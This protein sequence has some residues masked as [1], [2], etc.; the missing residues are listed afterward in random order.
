MTLELVTKSFDVTPVTAGGQ[1]FERLRVPA[2][3]HGF[4]LEP[5]LPQ[6]PLKGILMEIPA[7]QTGAGRGAGCHEPGA[8][9]L[10]GLPGAVAPGG[11]EQP[12][13]GGLQLGRGRLPRERLLPGGCGGAF[14]RV[15]VPG[16]GAAAADLLPPAVQPG[17]RGAAAL[18]AAAGAG[19]I[20]T[21]P[22]P[23]H[24]AT[25]D[26]SAQQTSV[27]RPQQSTGPRPPKPQA[28]AATR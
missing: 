1:A 8:R 16:P 4:T 14:H 6:V 11:R 28:Q 24:K 15:R 21:P 13:G 5:G 23:S 25:A 12:G 17:H 19:R 18:R 26:K 7:R 27:F 10:P 9:G 3:V 20:C 22:P 2:Y